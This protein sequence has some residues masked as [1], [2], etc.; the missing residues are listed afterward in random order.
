MWWLVE[1]KGHSG[2]KGVVY[3]FL[4]S[5]VS[6]VY[7]FT[8][9]LILYLFLAEGGLTNSWKQVILR[10]KKKFDNALNFS[11]DLTTEHERN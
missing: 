10:E 8:Y 9:C 7:L 3:L 4:F 5:L 6:F 11:D 1:L 2:F